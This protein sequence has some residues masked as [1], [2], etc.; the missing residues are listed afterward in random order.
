MKNIT[1]IKTFRVAYIV[2]IM[3]ALFSILYPFMYDYARSR[4]QD[5]PSIPGY[6]VDCNRQAENVTAVYFDKEH[7]A[8]LITWTN[9]GNT[10]YYSIYRLYAGQEPEPETWIMLNGMITDT[11]YT[12]TY[13]PVLDT[14]YYKYAVISF[15]PGN[16][17]D[18]S[19]S[20]I[21]VRGFKV[22]V[23]VNIWPLTHYEGAQVY[24]RNQNGNSDYIYS[25]ATPADGWVSFYD[26]LPGIYTLTVTPSIYYDD[27]VLTN[28]SVYNDLTIT[29][30]IDLSLQPQNFH[31]NTE[32]ME[33]CWLDPQPEYKTVYKENFEIGT[34]PTGWIQVYKEDSISWVINTG[35]PS[36]HPVHAYS[37][38]YNIS[39]MGSQARTMIITPPVDLS[40]AL[41]PMVIFW[42][43]QV[44]D[45]TGWNHLS[46]FYRASAFDTWHGLAS[47]DGEIPYWKRECIYLPVTSE[48]V[49]IAFEASSN[50]PGG[51]GICLDD[52]EVVSALKPQN[53]PDMQGFVC[54]HLSLDGTEVGTYSMA[55][56]HPLGDVLPGSHS[57]SV[58][59]EF[60]SI[61]SALVIYLFH[62]YPCEYF[63]QPQNFTGMVVGTDVILTWD[64]PV[65]SGYE[66]H[67]PKARAF[68][69][70]GYNVFRNG[71][72][73]NEEPLTFTQYE[74]HP[75]IGDVFDYNVTAMWDMG[76]S[77]FI[78]PSFEAVT[79]CKPPTGLTAEILE[80]DI[81]L[82]SWEPPD[83]SIGQWIHWDDGV[84]YSSIGLTPSG[85][86]W[87]A[88][89][90]AVEDLIPYDGIVLTK[91]AFFPNG[92]QTQYALKVWTGENAGSLVLDQPLNDL[93]IGVW[94]AVT[95]VTPVPIDAT[96]ELWF[97]YA[98]IDQPEGE[99]PAG[100]DAG[101][102]V[103]GKGDLITEDGVTWET[104]SGSG[105]DYNWNIQGYVTIDDDW[106]NLLG[107][108]VYLFDE[109]IALVQDTFYYYTSPLTWGI[110][111]FWVSALYE[112]CES[113]RDG[114][115]S[116]VGSTTALQGV[117]YDAFNKKP[118]RGAEVRL[119]P[120]GYSLITGLDGK[121]GF[122]HF[123][124]GLINIKADATGYKLFEL[125]THVWFD[126]LTILD[127]PMV[128]TFAFS[129]PF[130]ENWDSGSFETQRWTFD[131]EQNGWEIDIDTGNPPPSA[132]FQTLNTPSNYSYSLISPYFDATCAQG[133]VILNFDLNMES[134]NLTG[135]EMLT[136]KVWNGKGW[137]TVDDI[138]N[139]SLQQWQRHHYN[140]TG[141][142]LGK[143]TRLR[144]TA[145]GIN[146]EDIDFWQIDN[147]SVK[148]QVIYNLSGII[149]GL[150]I[151]LPPNLT[152][153]IDNYY[154]LT[155][156]PN[157]HFG[158]DLY[159][160]LH[161]ID[162]NAGC[163]PF[164]SEIYL[165]S[166]TSII[167][168]ITYPEMSIDPGSIYV[169][170]SS[171]TETRYLT[172][173]NDGGGLL[174]WNAYLQYP[175]E[176]PAPEI[177]LTS[178]D[179]KG[180]GIAG[181]DM[182]PRFTEVTNE[183]GDGPW[184]VRF[185]HDVSSA[186]GGLCNMSGVEFDGQYFYTTVWNS[187][188]ILKFN[189]YGDWLGTFE[190]T[191]VA[192]LR[193]LAWDGQYLYGGCGTRTEIYKISIE[194]FTVVKIISTPV[195]VRGIAWDSDNDAFWVCD[196]FSD[197]YLVA[198]DGNIIQTITNPGIES[199]YGLAYDAVTG[200]PAL[201]VFFQGAPG[202]VF[203][204]V[205][206]ATGQITET[207]DILQDIPGLEGY[208]V[209][210]GAF[211]STNVIPGIKVLGGL[212]Q[213]NKDIVF[214]MELKPTG[215]LSLEKYSG[216]VD[217]G[218][219]EDL[220]VYFN[221]EGL[222][223]EQT[224][225]AAI[226]VL[227]PCTGDTA[228]IDVGFMLTTGIDDQDN[229]SL[230][231][232]LPNPADDFVI[233][234][235]EKD[236]YQITLTNYLG[237]RLFEM[238]NCPNHLKIRISDFRNGIYLI[239]LKSRDG[240]IVTRKL[241]IDR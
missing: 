95:L 181:L 200:S 26:V 24:L 131:P 232:I 151:P 116:I 21:L 44:S 157:G 226:R 49:G 60:T 66:G 223:W 156:D 112:E 124:G 42:H 203:A 50:D 164:T 40:D 144:F 100:C 88:S 74:D 154:N 224:Y 18:T 93:V 133:N 43:T 145:H 209:A 119:F 59:T 47:F 234:E 188:K 3:M 190:V 108:K 91:I 186:S 7:T 191:G 227:S 55:G 86:F 61:H 76:E 237:Q 162:I 46:V 178:Y 140:I 199:M 210:G 16:N 225:Q 65:D 139:Q 146:P 79:D 125:E 15:D 75:F 149:E 161:M 128:D 57:A 12:D 111:D 4:P 19:F 97:G 233:I 189:V 212:I 37:G 179:R 8:S 127:I 230:I 180:R 58:Y 158:M 241:V 168:Q 30:S 213:A 240:S 87:V 1:L 173:E 63:N 152:V 110:F 53:P 138:S 54:Y 2:A 69:L 235:S 153:T 85:S 120:E 45:S 150:G 73:L 56:C 129:L 89:R 117:V 187:D 163:P 214:G 82:L 220:A 238:A 141:D 208:P 109:S 113:Y 68:D 41:L 166:D 92:A 22:T 207:H 174:T 177:T 67:S 185:V 34:I 62:N 83:S 205:D 136:V 201:W 90:W 236:I 196:W 170:T 115:A 80:G 33:A 10:N 77:C 94:N 6:Q 171:L 216:S 39:F 78:D 195:F 239:G 215:W 104:L 142:A 217:P 99:H 71:I 211:I 130:E 165:Q 25:D 106:Y 48:S 123:N 172:I 159:E 122:Y 135:T 183:R 70:L 20:N 11:T 96:Q 148:D 222:Q 204:R 160:G 132:R 134:Q 175:D 221:G 81:V 17:I 231:Q 192:H 5:S 23:H 126:R 84:N 143:V 64:P 218:A 9:L 114:P 32:T 14:G 197:L 101:P 29:V 31:V 13:W 121:Y 27:C 193:D 169:E 51:L 28:V 118:V 167:C 219:L 147:I 102:A 52:I 105:L 184:D 176:M 137:I 182:S 36:G 198:R 228:N 229:N 72:Q 103:P 107:Y 35:G 202:A 38:N 194:D 155:P 98:C 206:I